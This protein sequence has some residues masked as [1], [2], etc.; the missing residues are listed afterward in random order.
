MALYGH[1]IDDQTTPWEAGLSWVVKPAKGEFIGRQAL[2]DQKEQGVPRKLIGF[3][4][5]SRGI[6]RQG[7]TVR[8]GDEELGA[9]TS[10]T[11]SPTFQKALGLAY[12]PPDWAEPGT[13]ISIEVRG[14]LLDAQVVELPFYRRPK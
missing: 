8:N 14:R 12:V 4:V 13:E 5:T 7:H 2:M 1:E 3:E 10:G 11:Y 9:V 6:A